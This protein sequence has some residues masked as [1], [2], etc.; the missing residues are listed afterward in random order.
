MHWP[1]QHH[2][3]SDQ[4]LQLPTKECLP[5]KW[6]L[7]ANCINLPSLSYTERQQQ[8]RNIQRTNREWIQSKVLKSHRNISPQQGQKLHRTEQVRL[9]S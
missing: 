2:I 8:N 9:G 5:S 7:S 3:Q 1:H 6:T 4:K